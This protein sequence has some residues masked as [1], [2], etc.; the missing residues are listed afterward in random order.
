MSAVSSPHLEGLFQA[1]TDALLKVMAVTSAKVLR[2]KLSTGLRDCY[3][4]QS[5]RHL[6]VKLG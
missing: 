3:T 2:L 4:L 1:V 6:P 5:L